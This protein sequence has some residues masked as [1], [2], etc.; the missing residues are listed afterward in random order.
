[1]QN[2]Q[3]QKLNT[4]TTQN[5]TS[6]VQIGDFIQANFKFGVTCGIVIEIKKSIVV[7]KVCRQ[8][9]NEYTLTDCLTNITKTRILQIG[10]KQGETII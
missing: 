2:K 3:R 1:M 9:Y 7:I 8:F 4:M 10:L 5:L 6:E